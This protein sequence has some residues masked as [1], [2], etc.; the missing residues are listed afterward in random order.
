MSCPKFCYPR[1]KATLEKQPGV[2]SVELFPQAK[3]DVID[4]PRVRVSLTGS[5]DA[6][7]AFSALDELGFEGAKVE[8]GKPAAESH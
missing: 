5:F 3:P 1:V 8:E 6:A 7:K 2:Q 4:D